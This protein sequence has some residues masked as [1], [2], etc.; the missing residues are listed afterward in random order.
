MAEMPGQAVSKMH[1]GGREGRALCYPALKPFSLVR[2]GSFRQKRTFT[3][4]DVNIFNQNSVSFSRNGDIDTLNILLN[5]DLNDV[6]FSRSGHR[7]Q[8]CHQRHGCNSSIIFI[9]AY[10]LM[11]DTPCDASH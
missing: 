8:G 2:D 3:P 1:R 7:G 9:H 5:I 4:V 10:S 6:I 11:R